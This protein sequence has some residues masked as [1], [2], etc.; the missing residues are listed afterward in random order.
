MELSDYSESLKKRYT[1]A[2][3]RL[4][5]NLADLEIEF[6]RMEK[7]YIDARA[8]WQ[9]KEDRYE[10]GKQMY[11]NRSLLLQEEL[12]KARDIRKDLKEENEKL[13][14][15]VK[16]LLKAEVELKALVSKAGAGQGASPSSASAVVEV[17]V[18][19]QA[20]GGSKAADSSALESDSFKA[21]PQK[22]ALD[23]VEEQYKGVVA[24][25]QQRLDSEIQ[26]CAALERDGTR[27]RRKLF[28]MQSECDDM[29]DQWDQDVAQLKDLMKR[30]A[31]QF[32]LESE[33][34]SA[35]LAAAVEANE[36]LKKELKELRLALEGSRATRNELKL[37]Q[38]GDTDQRIL[39]KQ[40]QKHGGKRKIKKGFRKVQVESV[41]SSVIELALP[42]SIPNPFAG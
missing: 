32:G 11:L 14:E 21:D 41:L 37:L 7:E 19:D 5:G 16:D 30:Q 1:A 36:S 25:M 18:V 35:E 23:E 27:A 33:G 34:L 26:K 3:V 22:G 31:E 29:A 9:C 38:Q 13:R 40:K 4:E 10:T 20:G 2:M 39:Q 12:A 17:E 28:S 15:E 8:A 42:Q 6:S 24:S